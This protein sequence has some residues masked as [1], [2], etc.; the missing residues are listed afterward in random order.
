MS[1]TLFMVCA[2]VWCVLCVWSV[3]VDVG[4]N[5]A[6]ARMSSSN[7]ARANYGR[8]CDMCVCVWA[9]E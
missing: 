2:C 3:E 7:N 9:N 1:F 5:E 4:L 8:V 6:V